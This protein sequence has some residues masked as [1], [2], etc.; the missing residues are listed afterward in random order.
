[1]TTNPRIRQCAAHLAHE[2]HDTHERLRVPDARAR[3]RYDWNELPDD[4]RA[5]LAETF[6]SLVY[7]GVILC[8]VPE[9]RIGIDL[10]E[11]TA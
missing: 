4:E 6:Y 5:L 2:F 7:R 11:G 1:M 9:H 10:R 8:P 3:E